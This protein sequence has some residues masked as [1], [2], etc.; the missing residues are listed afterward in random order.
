VYNKMKAKLEKMLKICLLSFEQIIPSSEVVHAKDTHQ[1]RELHLHQP[2][3]LHL[4]QPREL[5][6][7]HQPRELHLLHQPREL[8][9][10]HQPR[11][12]H[13][14]QPRELHLHQLLSNRLKKKGSYKK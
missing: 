9:L 2:R 5:H 3:E 6:L 11:E 14:H 13:L 12:L 7:L 1:T 4:H 8:H 10:L